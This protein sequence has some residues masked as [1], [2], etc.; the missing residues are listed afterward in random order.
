MT[1]FEHLQDLWQAQAGPAVSGADIAALTRSLHIYGRRQRWVFGGKVLAVSSILVWGL[2]RCH[3]PN[4]IAGLLL[5]GVAAAMLLT[6]EWRNQRRISKLDFTAP[7]LPFV[8]R[9]IAT[10]QA[11]TNPFRRVYWLFM[12]IVIL[13]MNLVLGSA[14]PIWVRLIA[15]SLPFGG[16]ELGLWVRRKRLAAECRPL[17]EQLSAMQAA[18]EERCE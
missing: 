8:R 6:L 13:S 11:H 7:S 14:P 17:L 5:V 4:Q 10:L 15:S 2:A 18:L 1:R 9:A 16:V 3:R 12:A